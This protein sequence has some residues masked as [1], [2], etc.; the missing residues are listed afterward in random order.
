MTLGNP[1]FSLTNSTSPAW[2]TNL[3][4]TNAIAGGLVFV[5]SNSVDQL[6]WFPDVAK[7]FTVNY[8]STSPVGLITNWTSIGGI[9][10]WKFTVQNAAANYA[11]PSNLRAT[12][13]VKRGL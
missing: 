7:N 6:T 4:T 1:G 8:S 11:V 9:P 13:S 12:P 2:A 5:A 10:F 3:I